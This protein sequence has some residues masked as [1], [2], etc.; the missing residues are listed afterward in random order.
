MLRGYRGTPSYPGVAGH[1]PLRICGAHVLDDGRSLF[2]EIPELQPVNQLHL[3]LHVN[4]DDGYP[5]CNPA[6]HG[7]DLFITVHRLDLAFED[8]PN[9]TSMEKTIAAH[10]MLSDMA[11]A[12]LRVPNPWNAAIE[13]ARPIELRTGKN[14]T[15]ETPEIRVRASEPI[16]LS[17]INPDVVPHNWVLVKPGTLAQVGE[18]ANQLIANPE[19]FARNYIPDSDLVLYYTDIV[20]PGAQQT[21]N[22]R[23]PTQPGRYPFLCT[24]PGHWMVMNGTLIV[25]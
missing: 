22:I 5:V 16:A 24:F 21:V 15:Y 19:A 2:L 9:Y 17:L 3:R 18:L 12:T 11:L 25:E 14:L 10:P 1:D 13:G 7:H 6:G 8:F 4:A 23:A 20:D